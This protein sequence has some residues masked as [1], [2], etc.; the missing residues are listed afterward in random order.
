MKQLSD[1]AEPGAAIL[2]GMAKPSFDTIVRV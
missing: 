2:V 1:D